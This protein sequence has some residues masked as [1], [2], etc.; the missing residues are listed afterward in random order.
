MT[1]VVPDDEYAGPAV[2][3]AGERRITVRV[4][5]S[6]RFEPVDGRYH[7]GGRLAPHSEVADLLRGGQRAITVQIGRRRA[8]RARLAEIDPWGGIRLT[9]VSRPP[10]AT[11]SVPTTAEQT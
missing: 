7:W 6:G 4:T 2:I 5:L 11:P 1:T 3:Q 9:G 10:W 8:A